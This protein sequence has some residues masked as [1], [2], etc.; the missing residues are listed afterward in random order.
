V[1]L[2][3]GETHD[4]A[5]DAGLLIGIGQTDDGVNARF[6][7]AMASIRL[8]AGAALYETTF[9][10]P[11]APLGAAPSGTTELLMI[12]EDLISESGARDRDVTQ[13]GGVTI[14]SAHPA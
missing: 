12:A 14:A 11:A 8:T 9:T 1:R 4:V 3:A 7:G 2:L 10:P 5:S 13:P 6:R